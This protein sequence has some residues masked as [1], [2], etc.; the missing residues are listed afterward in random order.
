ML[1]ATILL[2]W[3][4]IGVDLSKAK[5]AGG[6]IGPIVTALKSPQAVPWAL[7]GLVVYF[8]FKCSIE[9]AQCH[10]DR[11]KLAFARADLVSAWIVSLAAIT[12][13][14]GQALSRAQFADFLQ[15]NRI[16]AL[17]F[18]V[19]LIL[20]F[21]AA[22]IVD[23]ILFWK[24]LSKRVRA[25]GIL[26]PVLSVASFVFATRIVTR[27]AEVSPNWRNVLIGALVGL[28]IVGAL[29]FVGL[30]TV[31]P[32]VRFA[33]KLIRLPKKSSSNPTS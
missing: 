7:T 4:L 12:L 29:R 21:P 2:V 20:V 6:N 18:G 13:Y 31:D 10:L 32:V 11:R 17:S 16:W 9:W 24:G 30:R 27:Y 33:Q 15:K 8:L 5:D 22:P 25:W 23:L 28:P 1:W 26:F 14:M 3:E 19:G